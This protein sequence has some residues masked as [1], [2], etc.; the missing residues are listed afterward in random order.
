[1]DIL[2][3]GS[4]AYDYL[5]HFPGKFRDSLIE[6]K[7]DK[8]SLSFLV[9]DMTK[10]YGGVAA[11]IAY[12]LGLLGHRPRLFGAVGQDF[13]D[14]R[15]HLESVG[16]D[17]STVVVEKK[18]FTASFFCNTDTENNQIASFYAGAMALAGN[19][20]IEQVSDKKPDLVVISPDDPQAMVNRVRECR[21]GNIPYLY[22]PSQQVA[23][24][25][26]NALKEGIEGCAVLMCNEYEWE[27]IQSRTGFTLDHLTDSECIFINTLGQDG[28][29]IYYNGSVIH[30]P[31]FA[32]R[33]PKNPTGAGDAYRAGILR[34][35]SLNLPWH[36][37]GRVASLCG[38]Y[39]LEHDGT[40]EHRFTRPEFVA[41]LREYFDDEGALDALL[42]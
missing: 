22:D 28:S 19:Y 38:T 40:Q 37:T 36:V 10:H 8:V 33:R 5:M 17:T 18:V 2:I 16:V 34:G 23:R 21:E 20:R 15:R 35:M 11:N 3:S 31:I 41:R 42:K 39:A 1:M 12:T 30:I 14:Y 4:I 24:L 7:L 27:I 26:G 13:E 32:P 6:Q 29:N 25:D 9:E